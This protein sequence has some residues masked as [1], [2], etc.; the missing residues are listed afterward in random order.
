METAGN[1]VII[2][3]INQSINQSFFPLPFFAVKL[4]LAAMF[5]SV[6]PAMVDGISQQQC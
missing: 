3:F 6:I 1:T 4:G 5:L 2:L